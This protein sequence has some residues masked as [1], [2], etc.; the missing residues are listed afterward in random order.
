MLVTMLTFCSSVV[1]IRAKL[2]V[3]PVRGNQNTAEVLSKRLVLRIP[4][5][6]R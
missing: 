6:S 5:G 1:Q 4:V 3:S 2:A